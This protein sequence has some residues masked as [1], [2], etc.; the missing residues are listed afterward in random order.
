MAVV[1]CITKLQY[2]LTEQKNLFMFLIRLM[3]LCAYGSTRLL[4]PAVA[5]LQRCMEGSVM[6][7][8]RLH[9]TFNPGLEFGE[10]SDPSIN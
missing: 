7:Q 5:K 4:H 6:S 9:M 10:T 3:L 2:V 1:G 8:Y